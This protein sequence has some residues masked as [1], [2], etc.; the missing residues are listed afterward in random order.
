MHG[1]KI[2]GGEV[3]TQLDNVVVAGRSPFPHCLNRL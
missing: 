2:Y 1:P 3:E